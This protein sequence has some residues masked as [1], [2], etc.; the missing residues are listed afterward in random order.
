MVRTISIPGSIACPP[1][2]TSSVSASGWPPAIP[3]HRAVLLGRSKPVNHWT[4]SS[5]TAPTYTAQLR[6]NITLEIF[7]RS[8]P[9]VFLGGSARHWFAGNYE[10]GLAVTATAVEQRSEK[11]RAA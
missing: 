8:R 4:G 1:Y 2:S 11:D 6:N 5:P 7:K 3:P 10:K 9:S